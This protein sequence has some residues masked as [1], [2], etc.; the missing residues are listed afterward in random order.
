MDIVK[1]CRLFVLFSPPPK[2]KNDTIVTNIVRIKTDT[3]GGIGAEGASKL[4][5]LLK[6][7]TTL[8]Q[9]NLECN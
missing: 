6:A 7:N 1:H 2:I 3:Y 4:S 5:R 8:T 9:L